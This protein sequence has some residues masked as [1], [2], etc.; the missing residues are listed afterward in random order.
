MTTTFAN[1]RGSSLSTLRR[2]QICAAGSNIVTACNSAQMQAVVDRWAHPVGRSRWA[3]HHGQREAE[4]TS[5]GL[6]VIWQ[7]HPRSSRSCA[8]K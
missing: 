8:S 2:V 1:Q 7:G 3:M 5:L 4:P 6:D